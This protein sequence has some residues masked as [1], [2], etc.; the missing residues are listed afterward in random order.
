M[1]EKDEEVR[2]LSEQINSIQ[3]QLDEAQKE[4][5]EKDVLL[6][7]LKRETESVSMQT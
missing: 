2:R 5:A 1:R 4:L 7:N 6:S 3:S